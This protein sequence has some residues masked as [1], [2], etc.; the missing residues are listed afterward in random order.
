MKEFKVIQGVEAPKKL[1]EVILFG[2]GDSNK[3]STWSNVPYLFAKTL[4][5]KGIT[6]RRVNLET[7]L[8]LKK[9]LDHTLLRLV[10]M[11]YPGGGF[12]FGR[13]KLWLYVEEH[14]IKKAVK[15]YATADLC[16]FTN[17]EHFNRY[18]KIPT[19]LFSDWTYRILV[20]EK[21]KRQ[22]YFFEKAFYEHQEYVINHAQYVICLFSNYAEIM[23]RHYPSA[24]IHFLGDNVINSLYD[25]PMTPE[26]ILPQKNRHQVLF[27]G[28]KY[29][30]EGL[31]L[32]INAFRELRKVIADA[33]LHV[34]GMNSQQIGINADFVHFHG[35][36]RKDNAVEK[37]EYYTLLKTSA[38]I[39]NITPQWGGYSSVIEAMY[40]YTPVLV[41][42][43]DSFVE[44]FGSELPFGS[45][46]EDNNQKAVAS[47]LIDILDSPD[48]AKLCLAAHQRVKGYTW[49][50]YIDRLLALVSTS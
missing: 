36:L 38:V 24:N 30:K 13:S 22:P 50:S 49:S 32:L 27:I 47:Q 44:E 18:S 45:Y 34:I 40:F 23:K 7:F 35:Y 28:K 39:V 16:I 20:E 41:T 26:T 2:Y 4:E 1:K 37:N 15:K 3:A 43:F 21:Q 8:F 10:K 48:Y 12:S 19:L 17:Y 14:K 46:V 29:Y 31:L 25:G 42:P 9:V 11:K 5:E 6:V 33:E